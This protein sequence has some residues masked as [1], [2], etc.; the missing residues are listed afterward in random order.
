MLK[1]T[2]RAVIVAGGILATGMLQF[3]VTVPAHAIPTGSGTPATCMASLKK[4]GYS[5]TPEI[6][7]GCSE[8]K[9]VSP[10]NYVSCTNALTK[11]GVEYGNAY[12]ACW[13][14]PEKQKEFQGAKL[15]IGE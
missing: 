2:Q 1:F 3:S 8:A 7:A 14:R 5:I 4:W 12:A 6:E 15:R 10:F 9:G 13:L 11:A